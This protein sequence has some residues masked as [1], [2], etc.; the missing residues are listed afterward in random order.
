MR[1]TFILFAAL[2]FLS[3][4]TPPSAMDIMY[5]GYTYLAGEEKTSQEYYDEVKP[6]IMDRMIV[7]QSLL[8]AYRDMHI[9]GVTQEKVNNAV[10]LRVRA[11]NIA[12]QMLAVRSNETTEPIKAEMR[13]AFAVFDAATDTILIAIVND[14]SDLLDSGMLLFQQYGQITNEIVTAFERLNVPER[15]ST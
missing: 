15:N 1:F 6:L 3:G 9:N 10:A 11:D 2:L 8:S 4:C 7:E 12:I 5:V 13:R 14:D